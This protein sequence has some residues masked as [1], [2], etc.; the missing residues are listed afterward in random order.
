MT[1]SHFPL[2]CADSRNG[3]AQIRQRGSLGSAPNTRRPRNSESQNPTG[4][5]ISTPVNR[6]GGTRVLRSSE[7][8]D[9]EKG[10]WLGRF[11][12]RAARPHRSG[13]GAMSSKCSKQLS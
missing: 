6:L 10:L 3:A 12:L 9:N 11:V 1:P 4:S 13:A 8:H 5:L 2:G 7:Y